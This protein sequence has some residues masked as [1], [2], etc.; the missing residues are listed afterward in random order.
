MKKI[1]L[2]ILLML[3]SIT[4][5]SCNNFTYNSNDVSIEE[6]MINDKDNNIT[7]KNKYSKIT[8]SKENGSITSLVNLLTKK[9]YIQN[10]VGGNWAMNVDLSTNDYYNTNLKSK[11]IIRINSRSYKPNIKYLETEKDATIILEYNIS[12]KDGSNVYEGIY[13]KCSILMKK[14]SKEVSIDYKLENNLKVPSVIVN[15]TGLIISGLKDDEGSLNLFWPN[16]EGKIYEA[17]VKKAFTTLKL[18]EQYPSPISMQLVQL[19]DNENSFYYYVKDKSRE[20]KEFNFGAYNASGE[21][22]NGSVAIAD[23]VSLSCTQYP[24]LASGESKDLWTTILGFDYRNQ[25]YSGSDSYR[26]F[27]ISSKM[28][29]NYN[30]FV[31]EWTGVASTTIS[32]Y[33]NKMQ[34]PYVGKNSP[35]KVIEKK[36]SMGVDSIILF[37]WHQGGFDSM[38][39]DYEFFEGDGYGENN[40]KQMVDT[41]HSNGDKALPYLNAHIIDLESK[42]GN[43][44]VNSETP[45]T[46][47]DNSAVKK[48]GFNSQV[49]LS[50]YKDYMYY[51]TYGTDTGYYAACPN[52]DEYVNQIL[53]SVEKLAKC[54]VDGLW[55]DQMME[56]PAYLCYD[57]N[58]NHKNPA[59]AYA[60]GYKKLYNFL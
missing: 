5:V 48:M 44:L 7:L 30:N 24:Y 43:K 58:H 36:D 37:G 54:G 57:K 47:L 10:S 38:Y 3:T 42:W 53:I 12:I 6:N 50:K 34:T 4:T 40:F 32:G 49:E 1:I 20:Y 33:G 14:D 35:D 18:G 13:V 22:D 55:M 17:G 16:K 15:F 21:Y 26:S 39:P 19:Y 46:N 52:S 11:S 29:R 27:L 28:N 60:E 25:W 2:F 56:M 23:K 8:I 41:I 9:D 31:N 59:T 45:K 51:E